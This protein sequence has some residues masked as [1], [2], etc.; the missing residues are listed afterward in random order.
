MR[1]ESQFNFATLYNTVEGEV[2]VLTDVSMNLRI[3][4]KCFLGIE[5]EGKRYLGCIAVNDV[6]FCQIF[7][8]LQRHCGDTITHIGDLDV[9]YT[10]Q[11]LPHC[12]P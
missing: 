3:P 7:R 1:A 4:N 6:A 5:H 11:Y 8:L 10:L 9:S 12:S 2:G